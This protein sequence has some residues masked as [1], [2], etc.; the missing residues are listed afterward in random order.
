MYVCERTS[1]KARVR[2]HKSASIDK[3]GKVMRTQTKVMWPQAKES[4]QPPDPGRRKV[5][6]FP[7]SL[8]SQHGLATP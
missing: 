6:I 2:A 5:Q 1:E 8:W 3:A 7:Q 4:W